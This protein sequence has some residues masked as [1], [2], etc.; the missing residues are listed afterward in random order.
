MTELR[1]MQTA[2]LERDVTGKRMEIARMRLGIG[3]NH[4][5]DTAKYRRERKEL[6]RMLTVLSEKQLN[7]S[8]KASTVRSPSARKKTSPSAS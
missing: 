6:A 7:A 8:Q 1:K 3:L 5:K 4:E 2:D